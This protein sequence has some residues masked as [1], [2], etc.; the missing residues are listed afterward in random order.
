MHNADEE[1]EELVEGKRLYSVDEK[2]E[3]AKFG[4]G[5]V[6]EMEGKE[7]NLARVQEHGFSEPL[8]FKSKEGLH[9]KVPPPD[10]SV[11]D[12]RSCVG[13]FSHFDTSW[14]LYLYLYFFFQLG[15]RRTLDVMDTK[16][17]RNVEMSM[18]QWHKYWHSSEKES[19]LNVISLEFSHTRLENYVKAPLV[20]SIFTLSWTF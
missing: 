1:F 5:F 12:I 8:L 19:V 17:Q 4:P 7:F 16:T 6:K 2:L 3:S 10:F 15:S 9:I 13:E 18:K 20:V 14:T 11:K